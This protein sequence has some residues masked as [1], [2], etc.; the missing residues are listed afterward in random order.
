MMELEGATSRN[1]GLAISVA[2]G[3]SALVASELRAGVLSV[4]TLLIY[5][6]ADDTIRPAP[7]PAGFA[8]GG[9]WNLPKPFFYPTLE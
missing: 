3:V 1:I 8:D 2:A 9:I 7:V 6:G 5:P 4:F